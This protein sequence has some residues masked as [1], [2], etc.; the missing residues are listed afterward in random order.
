MREPTYPEVRAWLENRYKALGEILAKPRR[1]PA[2][3]RRDKTE[4]AMC[5]QLLAWLDEKDRRIKE[6]EASLRPMTPRSVVPENKITLSAF[7]IERGIGQDAEGRNVLYAEID[8]RF[9]DGHSIFAGLGNDRMK[10]IT[11]QRGFA[12]AV[13]VALFAGAS[14][15]EHEALRADTNNPKE[16][17]ILRELSK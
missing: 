16:S 14:K 3:N 9:S 6:L 15:A 5:Y 7:H 11:S 17:L 10:A 12:V 8:A 4:R 13:I 2:L 1:L